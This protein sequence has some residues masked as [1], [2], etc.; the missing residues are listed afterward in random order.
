MLLNF[1]FP[2]SRYRAMMVRITFVLL[3]FLLGACDPQTTDV[4][5]SAGPGSKPVVLTTNYPLYFFAS[6]IAGDAVDIRMPDIDG[7]PA[8]WVPGPSDLPQMQTADLIIINGAG[9]ESWLAF[10]TLPSG[11]L[12]DTSA[13]IQDQLLPIENEPLHQHGPEGAHSH[14]G[15]AFT[16]WLNP[17]IAIE[18]ARVIS[19]KLSELV[20]AQTGGFEERLAGLEEKLS[21]LDQSLASVFSNFEGQPVVFSH[22]VYQYLQQRYELN[23]QSVHWEPDTEPGLKEW[24]DFQNLLQEHPAKLMIWEGPPLQAMIERLQQWGI[25]SVIFDPAANQP[26]SGDYFSVMH[27]NLLRLESR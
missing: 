27:A 6:E 19:R 4:S 8:M 24:V 25:E 14:E 20:P 15:T 18:Q 16:T 22:P 17:Q 1:Y 11:L 21:V 10:T 3:F 5:L 23:G 12:V 13:D 9:Y 7:D 26:E 2:W